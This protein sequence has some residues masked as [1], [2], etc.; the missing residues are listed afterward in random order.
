[1]VKL[2]VK[3]SRL[4]FFI[5]FVILGLV[6]CSS[7]S[8]TPTI[9]NASGTYSGNIILQNTT[10]EGP[11]TVT[12]TATF[13]LEKQSVTHVGYLRVNETTPLQNVPTTCSAVEQPNNRLFC[14]ATDTVNSEKIEMT[15]KLEGESYK[16]TLKV[17]LTDTDKDISL[18]G[19]FNFKK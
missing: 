8:S 5:S 12:L 10:G 7:S 14:T 15:D 9:T 4:A 1:M 11:Q 18:E 13:Y 17:S 6:G 16:G 3:Y 19:S 2:H